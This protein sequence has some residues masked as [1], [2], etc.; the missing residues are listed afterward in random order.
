MRQY[1]LPAVIASA[2]LIG[3]TGYNVSRAADDAIA[4]AKFAADG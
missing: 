4:H 3:I 2:V 1:L